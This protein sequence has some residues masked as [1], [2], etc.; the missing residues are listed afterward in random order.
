MS[1]W[2]FAWRVA[3]YRPWLFLAGF[4]GWVLLYTLPILTGLLLRTFFDAL[5]GSAP[6]GLSAWAVVAL[7]VASEVARMGMFYAAACTWDVC[8]LILGTLL[9]ANLL[10]SIVLGPGPRRLPGSAGEAVSR[11]RDDVEEVL[12]LIDTCID[13]SGNLLFTAVAL[14][15][16][17]RIDPRITLVVFLPLA[18]IVFVTRALTARIRRYRHAS[19]EQTG[20]VMGFIGE[21]FGAVQAVKVAAAEARVVRRFHALNEARAEAAVRDRLFTEL[22]DSFNLNTVNLAMG[23][24]LLL[25]AGAMRMGVFTVG[26]FALFASYLTSVTAMP[27]WVGRLLARH[28]HAGVSAER[29][30]VL[31]PHSPPE[32]LARRAPVY[33]SGPLPPVPAPAR[34]A[35]RLERL[36]AVGLSYRY[37]EGGRGIEDVSLRLARGTFTVVT[38]RVGAGKT[39]LLR[40]LVGLLPRDVGVIRWNGR[41][42]DDPA[43]F[44]VPPRAAYTPQAPRLFS[45]SLRDNVLMGQPEDAAALAGALR[46]AVLEDDVA[47]MEQGLDT[48]VG[49]RGVRL[50]GGQVQRAAAARMFVRGAEL[51]VFDDLSSALDVETEA[52]LW[53]QLAARRD[54]TCLVVSHRRAALRRADH[55]IVLRDGHVDAEGTLDELL[56]V[57]AEM[58][59]LWHGEADP[60]PAD[61]I[62]VAG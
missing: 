17:L 6:L 15:I 57:S 43:T 53:R 29:M 12:L 2:A 1:T 13:L 59:R 60:A 18:A 49:P 27:R 42:I 37:P 22:L 54:V 55:I 35:D 7:V 51:L 48:L 20:R 4:W 14:V 56:A 58:R 5:A 30:A 34:P 9:R 11:F 32:S 10:A 41:V 38:G 28:R 21:M 23:V 33:L 50:S 39:T 3:F 52:T 26:D 36:E 44:F 19:R 45:E 8:W 46:L 16:M 62:A 40:V 25:A 47:A 24:I 61:D 31:V